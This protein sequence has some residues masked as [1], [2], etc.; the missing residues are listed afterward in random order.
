MDLGL[1]GKKAVVGAASRGLG[2][3]IAEELA[4]EGADVLICARGE[5][6]VADACRRIEERSGRPAH[7]IV[8]DVATAEGISHVAGEANRQLGVVDILITNAGGPPP[9]KFEVHEWHAWQAAVDLTLRSVVELVRAFLP[10]MRERRWGRIVNVSSIAAIQPVDNLLLSNSVR[11]AVTGFAKSLSNE[12]AADGVTV[13][14]V[15]PGYTRTERVESLAASTAAQEGVS[16]GDI[17]ARF[18]RQIPAG[19][20]GEA[21]ELAALAAFLASDRAGFITGQSIAVDGGWIRGH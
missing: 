20:L 7:G 17:I 13:N 14:N 19:R 10:G 1:A 4:M 3:A 9:G 16:P 6:G 8:A 12:V 21:G 5:Q 2:Y 15:L 11:A 18:E